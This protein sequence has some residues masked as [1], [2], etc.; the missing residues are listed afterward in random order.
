MKNKKNEKS[1]LIE[2]KERRDNSDMSVIEEEEK[3][4]SRHPK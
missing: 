4:L 3:N 2:K 1:M